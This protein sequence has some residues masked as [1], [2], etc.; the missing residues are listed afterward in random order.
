MPKTTKKRSSTGKDGTAK[1]T[2]QKRPRCRTCGKPIHIPQGWSV[3][4]A[5]R[6]HYWAKHRDVMLPGTGS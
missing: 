2:K 6:R 3:G 4:P 1:A 5:V